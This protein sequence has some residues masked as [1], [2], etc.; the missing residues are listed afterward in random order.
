MVDSLAGGRARDLFLQ[1]GMQEVVFLCAINEVELRVEHLSSEQN[2]I[3]D[4]LSR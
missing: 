2:R 1:A 3:A 4:H